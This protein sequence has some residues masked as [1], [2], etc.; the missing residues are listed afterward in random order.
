MPIGLT[1][2]LPSNGA[3]TSIVNDFGRLPEHS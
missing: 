2:V 3:A 1:S